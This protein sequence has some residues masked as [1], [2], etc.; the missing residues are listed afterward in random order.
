MTDPYLRIVDTTLEPD[1]PVL[2]RAVY[3]PLLGSGFVHPDAALRTYPAQVLYGGPTLAKYLTGPQGA[4]FSRAML[5]FFMGHQYN[6][7][8]QLVPI[9]PD[10]WPSGSIAP[11]WPRTGWQWWWVTEA[12][13]PD[14][15]RLV[16]VTPTHFDW[17]RA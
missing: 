1:A 15:Y 16:R 17:R 2:Y 4:A 9:A 14:Q 7:A 11:R 6:A 12:R 3:W 10:S 5:Y 8:D 13:P